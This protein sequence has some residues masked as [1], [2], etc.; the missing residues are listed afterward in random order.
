MRR[1]LVVRL[2]SLG[3]VVLTAPVY[4]NLKAHWPEAKICALVKPQFSAVLVEN[5]NVDEILVFRGLFT[6]LREIRKRG[7][8]HLLDLHATLRSF[9]LRILS[10]I[11]EVSVYQKHALARRLYVLFRWSSPALTKHSLERYLDSLR[12]WG[13]P[14]KHR[15]LELG[16]FGSSRPVSRSEPGGSND[17]WL[18][19]KTGKPLRVLLAQTSFLGDSLLTMPLARRIKEVLPGSRLFVVTR[20][21]TASVFRRSEAVDEIIE[22]DKRGRHSGVMGLLR[23]SDELYK[24]RLDIAFVAHRSLRSALLV[25]LAKIPRRIGFSSSAGSF[26][27]HR[28]V[29]FPWGMPE[30]ERNLGLL[31]PIKPDLRTDRRDALYLSDRG[32]G[33]GMTARL[34]TAGISAADR[35]V[36]IHPG[37]VWPTKRWFPE[38]FAALT[39][40]LVR[41]KAAKVVFI[42]GPNDRELSERIVSLSGVDVIDWVGKTDLPELMDLAKR[43]DLLVTNDSGPM[44]IAAANGVP[45]LA[46]FGPTT[47]EL[48]FFPYGEGHEVVEAE[49]ACRPCGLHGGKR[50]PE[51]HFLCMRLIGVDTVFKRCCAMLGAERR[52]AV[53]G[54]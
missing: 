35:L 27:F 54:G 7:F 10:G 3:D 30:V 15:E 37:S 11:P 8:T 20:P 40:R 22:D 50:C 6:T 9:L 43:L 28:T 18:P 49:L 39:R 51:G 33:P 46:I 14:V 16:D 38:R 53:P 32:T 12:A 5:P 29:A 31:L 1:I 4:K 47:R 17:E 45:T 34:E 13:V 42:G 25:W 41:E 21:E 48:G 2:S 36:G 19:R 23:L 26:L 44:H 24:N 52:R